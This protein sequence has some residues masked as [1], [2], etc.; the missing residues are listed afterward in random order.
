MGGS[1]QEKKKWMVQWS[2]MFRKYYITGPILEIYDACK[3]MKFAKKFCNNKD[4]NNINN[5]PIIA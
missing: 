2:I 3:H 5:K 4:N 1:C